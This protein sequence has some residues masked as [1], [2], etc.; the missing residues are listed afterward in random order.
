MSSVDRNAMQSFLQDIAESEHNLRHPEAFA[1]LVVAAGF[2][3]EKL[4]HKFEVTD[5]KAAAPAR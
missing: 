4:P 1:S 2:K 3:L 5:P